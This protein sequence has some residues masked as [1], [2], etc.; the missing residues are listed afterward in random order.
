MYRT[1]LLILESLI[2][3]LVMINLSLFGADYIHR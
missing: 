2:S 3:T 1:A